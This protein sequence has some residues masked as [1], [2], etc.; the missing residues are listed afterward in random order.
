MNQ[1]GRVHRAVRVARPA[2]PRHLHQSA[3][4]QPARLARG[5]SLLHA[6]AVL[7]LRKSFTGL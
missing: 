6:G 1:V 4:L 3:A 2:A 7:T 5:R